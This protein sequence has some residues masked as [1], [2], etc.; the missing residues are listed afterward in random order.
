M[1]VEQCLIMMPSKL[2]KDLGQCLV[3]SRHK[4]FVNWANVLTIE[5][6]LETMTSQ[7]GHLK[8]MFDTWQMSGNSKLTRHLVNGSEKEMRH[9]G[10]PPAFQQ[11]VGTESPKKLGKNQGKLGIFRKKYRIYISSKD[12]VFPPKTIYFSFLPTLYLPS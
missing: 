10:L 7:V 3:N 8:T 1:T 11:K 9:T 2:V 5:L 4:C 6:V 12:Y